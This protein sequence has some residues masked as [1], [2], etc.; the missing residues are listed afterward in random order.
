MTSV[1]QA[2]ARITAVDATGNTFQAISE[3]VRGLASSMKALGGVAGSGIGA[4]NK[5]V[6]A[7]QRSM[8]TLAPAAAGAAAYEGM[9]GVSGLIHETVQATA[10][11]A[12]ETIR[13]E[14]AGL[15]GTEIEHE[16]ALSLEMSHRYK[17]L[18]QTT[19]QHAL[20]N[21]RSVVGTYE[22]AAKILDPMLKLRVA[23]AGAHPEHAGELAEDFDKLIKGMEIKGVTMDPQK[24]TSYM[25]GMAKAINVFGDTLR[26]TDYYEMFKYGR[27]ATSNLSEEFM[28]KTAPT[29]AQELGGSS[30]GKALSSFYQAIVGGR[31]KEQ[32]VKAMAQLGLVNMDKVVRTKTGSIKGLMPGGVKGWQIAAHDPYAWVNE[33]LLPTLQKHG[34][35]DKDAIQARIGTIFQQATAAQLVSIFATQQARIKKDWALVGGAK[36]LDAADLYMGSDPFVAWSGVTEQF[37]NFL[38]AAGDPMIGPATAGLNKLSDAIVGME[39]AASKHP[40]TAA[41]ALVAATTGLGAAS[42]A[43]SI[44]ALRGILGTGKTLLNAGGTAVEALTGEAAAK[45]ALRATAESL[46]RAPAATNVVSHSL[47]G[48]AFASLMLP[49]SVGEG[50]YEL[51]RFATDQAFQHPDI[52][53][54]L[55]EGGMLGALAPEGYVEAAALANNQSREPVTAEVKGD[56]NLNVNVQV[57]PSP[58]FITRITTMFQNE[59]NAFRNSG[60]TPATGTAGSTGRSMPGAAPSPQ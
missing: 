19:I 31:I 16:K 46:F 60:G 5:T 12:H 55:A 6:G 1:L 24:F 9:H 30:T 18:S 51:G 59:I 20:R 45:A 39:K 2:E 11:G 43:A 57:E 8:R 50:S 49:A 21:M 32:S 41:G 10:A 28:L 38:R 58:D 15:T 3:K 42:A 54:P 37:K 27:Q 29:L 44:W 47:L 22:E 34:I 23:A 33:I 48:G 26:P 17:S 14:V 53:K 35:T 7:L 13:G 36:G 40:Y 4:A 52:Y 56:A 25:Q